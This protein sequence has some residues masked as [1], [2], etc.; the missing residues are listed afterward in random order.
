MPFTSCDAGIRGVSRREGEAA[1]DSNRII[2]TINAPNLSIRKLP[3]REG[4]KNEARERTPHIPSQA[5]TNP[6][7][8]QATARRFTVSAE[9]QLFGYPNPKEN[10]IGPL[11]VNEGMQRRGE[12]GG[13][14]S[15][16]SGQPHRE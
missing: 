16:K 8:E 9:L 4:G 6:L 1:P 7:G 2:V 15:R 14:V 5:P 3:P 11:G 10:S 12:L 13:Q